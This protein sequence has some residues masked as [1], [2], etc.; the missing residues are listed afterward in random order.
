M[1]VLYGTSGLDDLQAAGHGLLT[2]PAAVFGLGADMFADPP[3]WLT[4]PAEVRRRLAAKPADDGVLASYWPGIVELARCCTQVADDVSDGGTAP[5]EAIH[6][7]LTLGTAL[8]RRL[9]RPPVALVDA[10]AFP[11]PAAELIETGLIGSAEGW[12][13]GSAEGWASGSTGGWDDCESTGPASVGLPIGHTYLLGYWQDRLRDQ[14]CRL[15]DAIGDRWW[16][17]PD[18]LAGMVDDTRRVLAAYFVTAYELGASLP[19]AP[20]RLPSGP[21]HRRRARSSGR[22]REIGHRSRRHGR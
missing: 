12:A 9:P 16:T 11:V 14:A 7:A 1:S 8:A 21:T 10:A 6:R 19:P 15:A 22:D 17:D 18:A 13:S 2:D 3:E 4:V 5:V 20:R